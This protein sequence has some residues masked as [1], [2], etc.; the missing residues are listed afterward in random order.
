MASD[1]GDFNVLVVDDS[2]TSRLKLAA[3]VRHLGHAVE[4][5]NG[6]ESG[7]NSLRTGKI[8]LVLLDI[9]MPDIDGYEV[10]RWMSQD[11]DLS[12]TCP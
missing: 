9:V 5:A 2:P 10:L 7:L 11:S 12:V 1:R 4:E 3:A 6:G 8:D